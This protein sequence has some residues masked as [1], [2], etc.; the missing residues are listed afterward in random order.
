MLIQQMWKEMVNKGKKLNQT[1]NRLDSVSSQGEATSNE[2]SKVKRVSRVPKKLVKKESKENSPRSA[3][4]FSSRQ[5]HTK[6]HYVSSNNTLNKSP[7]TNKVANGARAL[8]V[9]KIETVKVPSCSS[10]EMSEET[11]DKA[12]EDRSTDDKAV[13]G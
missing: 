13:E 7:N 11:D 5:I 2:D 1:M 3:R 8:E 10:S 4:S 6:L 12:I 9:K